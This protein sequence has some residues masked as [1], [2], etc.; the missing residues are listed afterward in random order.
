MTKKTL[1]MLM[2]AVF[3]GICF[4]QVSGYV[5]S[6]STGIYT[7]ITG[8]TVLA[9]ATVGGTGTNSLDEGFYTATPI[10]FAFAYNGLQYTD[11]AISCNG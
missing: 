10:P 5:F 1:L 3:T 8:G 11:V 6:Y 9:T 7:E 4:A 2:L